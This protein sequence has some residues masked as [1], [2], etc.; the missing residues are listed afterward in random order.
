MEDG[1]L[2]QIKSL[3]LPDHTLGL[4][5]ALANF[6]GYINRIL[7]EKLDICIVVYLDNIPINTENSR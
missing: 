1:I 2:Y 6:Q 5:N 3:W 4:S 7:A